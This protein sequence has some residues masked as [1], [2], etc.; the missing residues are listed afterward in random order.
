VNYNR[1]SI[2]VANEA[3]QAVPTG[4]LRD[5]VGYMIEH[6]VDYATAFARACDPFFDLPHLET[7]FDQEWKRAG[8]E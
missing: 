7:L 8:G 5:F 2:R 6:N 1:P 3:E 4:K